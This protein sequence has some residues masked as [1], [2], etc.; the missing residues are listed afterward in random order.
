MLT[1][2]T[3]MPIAFYFFLWYNWF[4]IL[5]NFCLQLIVLSRF[6]MTVFSTYGKH[7]LCNQYFLQANVHSG[8]PTL[9]LC[10]GNVFL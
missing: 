1:E 7:V 2:V 3:L 9:F 8:I 6:E 5:L 4:I 10:R